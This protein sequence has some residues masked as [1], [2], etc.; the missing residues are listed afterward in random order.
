MLLLTFLNAMLSF[1]IASIV[2]LSVSS[3]H[4]PLHSLLVFYKPLEVYV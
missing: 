4:F 3:I 1:P 2:S